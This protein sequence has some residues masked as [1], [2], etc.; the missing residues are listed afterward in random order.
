[1]IGL[2]SCIKS[3]AFGSRLYT[4]IKPSRSVCKYNIYI[5]IYIYNSFNFLTCEISWSTLKIYVILPHTRVLF[6][7]NFLW[8]KNHLEIFLTEGT[9]RTT[10]HAKFITLWSRKIYIKS[11]ILQYYDFIISYQITS[12]FRRSIT[13]KSFLARAITRTNKILT[14]G[15]CNPSKHIV[16]KESTTQDEDE[17]RDCCILHAVTKFVTSITLPT[18]GKM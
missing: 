17:W 4:T 18:H 15:V 10:K 5:Y 7:I 8:L 16:K 11:L 12:T 2:Y 14:C 6:S 9:I 1:M 13:N 3:L